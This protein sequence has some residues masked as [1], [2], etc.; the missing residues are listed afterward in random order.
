MSDYDVA[1]VCPNGHVANSTC[2][3][4]PGL[5]KT[6]CERCGEKTIVACPD[7]RA[8]IRGE[9]TG[10]DFYTIGYSLPAFC[11][12]CGHAFP[13]TVRAMQV[14]IDLAT[15]SGKLTDLEQKQFTESV[16]EVTR[17]T[18]RT[19]VAASRM[20]R[21]LEK[22]GKATADAVRDVLVDVTSE[23]VKKVIWPS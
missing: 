22:A 16:H 8:P 5:T 10:G 2:Q 21:I 12:N 9:Y 11:H 15:E 4:L 19:Q 20:K 6:F 13:W 14:A 17:D 1:Q 23:A 18:P 3:L 7:C